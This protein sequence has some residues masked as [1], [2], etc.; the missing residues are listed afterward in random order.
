MCIYELPTDIMKDS[1]QRHIID[2][3]QDNNPDI[4]SSKR[5]SGYKM[6]LCS[7]MWQEA[8]TVN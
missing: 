6:S 7:R 5:R 3:G 2:L 8:S 1:Q 4:E